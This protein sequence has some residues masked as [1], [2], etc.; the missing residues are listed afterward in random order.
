VWA[1]A[2]DASGIGYGTPHTLGHTLATNALAA[3]ISLFELSRS[4][5][6][7]VGMIDKTFGHLAARQRA[8]R[9]RQAEVSLREH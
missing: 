9:A 7:S 6:T 4:M 2:L 3:G 8:G 5:G 1:P